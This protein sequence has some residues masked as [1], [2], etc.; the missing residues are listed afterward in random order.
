MA[1]RRC[2]VQATER[3]SLTGI[4][5]DCSRLALAFLLLLSPI[6]TLSFAKYETPDQCT[7]SAYNNATSSGRMSVSCQVRTLDGEGTNLSALQVE[8]TIRLRVQCSQVLLFES[9]LPPHVFQ[10]L[11]Q[12]EELI[13]E[14]CK[15]LQLPP[16]AFD[17]LRDLKRLSINTHNAEWGA[18][19]SM[20][21]APSS[22]HGL[23][24]LQ[25]L[26]LS[27]NNIRSLPEDAFC[28]LENLQILNLTRNRIRDADMLGYITRRN[29]YEA[30]SILP[31]TECVGGLDIR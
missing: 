26:D 20:E 11:N 21:L 18:S 28:Y 25:I 27:D 13:V 15:I 12:L 3:V 23:K 19:K 22:L 16:D 29:I 17:G 24:E 5:V 7:W 8:G 1:C 30:S 14:H 2:R 9:S 10:R 4:R 31:R 6:A